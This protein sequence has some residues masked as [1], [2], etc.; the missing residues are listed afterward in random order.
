M[1]LGYNTLSAIPRLLSYKEASDWERNTQP[2]R[3]DKLGTKPLGRRNQ[4]YINIK[5]A[6][7]ESIELCYSRHV[8]ARYEPSGDVL[9]FD[10]GYTIK[11]TINELIQ[12]VTNIR[13]WTQHSKCWVHVDG[14]AAYLRPNPR[15][16]WVFEAD[17]TGTEFRHRFM[18]PEGDNPRNVFRRVKG[19]RGMEQWVYVNAPIMTKH[20]INRANKKRVMQTYA[21][22]MRYVEVMNKLLRDEPLPPLEEYVRVFDLNVDNS[23][24]PH[25]VRAKLPPAPVYRWFTHTHADQLTTLMASDD[26]AH[27]YKALLWLW[28]GAGAPW[29]RASSVKDAHKAIIMAHHDE[30]L[31]SVE[32]DTRVAARDVYSWAIPSDSK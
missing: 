6:E 18:Q 3:G 9:L 4:K 12:R 32:F 20:V 8:F 1:A 26:I 14:K 13:T 19:E 10:D 24:G 28:R 30:V 23:V 5:R 16:R 22:F 25:V 11:A 17:A 2:I 27:H 21:P 31:D 29:Q 7:D 15:G